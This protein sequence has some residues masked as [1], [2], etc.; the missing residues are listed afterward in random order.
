MEET[1]G[2]PKLVS[3]WE[4]E[5]STAPLIP[6]RS[7]CQDSELDAIQDGLSRTVNE[8]GSKSNLTALPP[9]P[10]RP[11]RTRNNGKHPYTGE[12]AYELSGS[13]PLNG[14][15]KATGYV[16]EGNIRTPESDETYK[17]SGT[18]IYVLEAEAAEVHAQVER[19]AVAISSKEDEVKALRRELN[20]VQSRLAVNEANLAILGTELDLL[21]GQL[22]TALREKAAL[23]EELAQNRRREQD[24]QR[25]IEQA[26]YDVRRAQEELTREQQQNERLAGRQAEHDQQ[27]RRHSVAEDLLLRQALAPLQPAVSPL[28]DPG[29]ER[30]AS[31]RMSSGSGAR[32]LER[33]RRGRDGWALA[34]VSNIATNS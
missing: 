1:R 27:L 32:G 8:F 6:T 30:H 34:V 26:R 7:R 13:S 21:T 29:S 33:R 31:R 15:A 16:D 19:T 25:Q 24:L 10:P 23:E 28:A 4:A 11:S 3:Y 17:S 20:V 22:T 12:P 5:A 2:V 14:E 9:V 18:A